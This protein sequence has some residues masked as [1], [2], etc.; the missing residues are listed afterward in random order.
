MWDACAKR[1]FSAA[2]RRVSEM[3]LHHRRHSLGYPGSGGSTF[4]PLNSAWGKKG[5]AFVRPYP[6]LG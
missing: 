6:R 5:S 2:K 4:K 1:D 3:Q